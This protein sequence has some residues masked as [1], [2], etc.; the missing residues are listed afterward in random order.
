MRC[1]SKPVTATPHFHW[2]VGAVI[3]CLSFFPTA[4]SAQNLMPVRLIPTR[5]SKL[6]SA[7]RALEGGNTPAALAVLSPLQQAPPLAPIAAW[8]L[9]ASYSDPVHRSILGNAVQVSETPFDQQYEMA[10]GSFLHGRIRLDGL[11]TVSVMES[12]LRGLPG[13]GSLPSKSAT[14]MGHTGLSAPA[15]NSTYGF[16]LS[17]HHASIEDGSSALRIARRL[18]SIFRRG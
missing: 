13:S 6:V 12:F 14:P 8:T 3:L 2:F 9:P 16:S 11:G 7:P 5:D 1:C 10:F 17:L 18:G 4:A 15:M